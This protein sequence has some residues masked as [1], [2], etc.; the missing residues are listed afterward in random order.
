MLTDGSSAGECQLVGGW[1]F[2]SMAP[3][4]GAEVDAAGYETRW[5]LAGT[6]FGAEGTTFVYPATFWGF[7]TG[8]GMG[9]AMVTLGGAPPPWEIVGGFPAA[10]T[11]AP[12]MWWTWMWVGVAMVGA[13]MYSACWGPLRAEVCAW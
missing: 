13:V 3:L 4:R 5:W 11:P 6:T 7:D 9:L 12:D 2:T 1:D 8:M 10:M